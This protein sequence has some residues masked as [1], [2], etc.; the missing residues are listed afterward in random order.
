MEDRGCLDVFY[1]SPLGNAVLATHGFVQP[2]SCPNPFAR[3]GEYV[4]TIEVT[5]D[6][7]FQ[8]I[9]L[10]FALAIMLNQATHEIDARVRRYFPT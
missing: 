8:Q 5:S 4:L 2:N 10:L 9:Q 1:I 3:E 7:T 6:E